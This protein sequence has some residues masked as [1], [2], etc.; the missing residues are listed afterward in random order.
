MRE[1]W[2]YYR[3]RLWYIMVIIAL[4]LGVHGLY[5]YYS[6]IIEKPW[7]LMSAMLYGTMKLFL[8]APPIPAQADSTLSYQIAMWLAPL[9]TS[10]LVLTKVTNALLHFRNKWRNRFSKKHLVIFEKTE[11]VEALIANLTREHRYDI[12]LVLKDPINQEI[13]KNYEKKKVA[14]YNFNIETESAKDLESMLKSL[15]INRCVNILFGSGDDLENY[16]MFQRIIKSIAPENEMNMY[17]N[18]HSNSIPDYLEKLLNTGKVSEPKLELVD[19]IP[20][21]IGELTMRMLLNRLDDRDGFLKLN[22]DG[23]EKLS[24]EKPEI[25][26]DMIDS[27]LGQI[28]FLV[29]GANELTAPM[30]RIAANN[31]TLSLENNLK[32]TVIDDDA[33]QIV[34]K[35]IA[36]NE[37]IT[38]AVNIEAVSIELKSRMLASYLRTL[39]SDNPPTAIFL[40]NEDTITNLEILSTVDRFFYHEPKALRNTSGIDLDSLLPPGHEELRVFGDINEIM[41]ERIL[42]RSDLDRKARAFNDSYN[43]TSEK[44]G[45]GGGS[46]WSM[47]SQTKKN[48]SRASADHAVV[49]EAIIRSLHPSKTDAELKTMIDEKMEDFMDIQEKFG[50]DSVAFKTHFNEFL[51]LNPILDYLSRLE[52]KR[53]N[54]SYYAMN[55]RYG[56]EKDE[57]EKTH[58]CLID[59]WNEII[60]DSFYRCYPQYDLIASFAL[61]EEEQYGRQ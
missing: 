61:F 1:N 22:F 49:K 58:P 19:I 4:A 28:H 41:N 55:F 44:T 31:V 26:V 52:H 7:R 39:K 32:V 60:G 34:S 2:N 15:N 42:I 36:N 20:Y 43:R 33:E 11:E 35:F 48:S 18:T 46:S 6:P 24:K 53:W 13:K 40:M 51:K 47:L 30:L 16:S 59:D 27:G 12:S 57:Y 14:V 17:I 56:E 9:L 38:G 3:R 10:A 37:E 23:L 21:N 25:N 5:S 54:N 50:S 45:L 8:F 29:L